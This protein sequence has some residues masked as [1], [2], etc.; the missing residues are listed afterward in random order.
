MSSIPLTDRQARLLRIIETS[1]TKRGYVPTLQEMARAMDIASL[2]GV[3][4]HLTALERKGYLRRTPG[5]RR[6]I[7]VLQPILP[8][9]GSIPILGRVAAGRPLLA[10]E[11]REGAL[12]LDN[13]L[14]GNGA[15]FALHVQ[16]DSMIEA[17]IT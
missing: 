1:V 12:S 10:V 3:K 14:L 11:N 6:A 9:A 15:H 8:I 16:G 17:G 2:Q 5:R 7:E 13:S 4:D